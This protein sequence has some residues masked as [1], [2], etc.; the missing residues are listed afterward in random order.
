MNKQLLKLLIREIKAI[1]RIENNTDKAQNLVNIDIVL[2]DREN[3]FIGV[4]GTALDELPVGE[5]WALN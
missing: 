1:G 5:K 2:Y 4:I 3:K